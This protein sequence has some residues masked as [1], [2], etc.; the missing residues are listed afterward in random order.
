MIDDIYEG[1][2]KST[3]IR[4]ELRSVDYSR[5][6]SQLLRSRPVDFRQEQIAAIAIRELRS[7]GRPVCI[8]CQDR[9]NSSRRTTQD[10]N[11]PKAAGEHNGVAR[12]IN[13]KKFVTVW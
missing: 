5:Q 12:V 3:P 6:R 10:R 4:R 13:G 1:K 2:S 8:G 7:I 9:S 11:S